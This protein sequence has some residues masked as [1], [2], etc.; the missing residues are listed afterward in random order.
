MDLTDKVIL[1]TGGNGLIG[2]SIVDQIKKEKGVPISIDICH[3]N[4]VKTNK[5]LTET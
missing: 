3:E 5:Y 2:R 1:V 4:S